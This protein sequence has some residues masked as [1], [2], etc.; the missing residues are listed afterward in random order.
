M[1]SFSLNGLSK[2]FRSTTDPLPDLHRM[3]PQVRCNL[4]RMKD[5]R[6]CRYGSSESSVLLSWPVIKPDVNERGSNSVHLFSESIPP[7]SELQLT[8]KLSKGGQVI[9]SLYRILPHQSA[10]LGAPLRLTACGSRTGRP[11][12][13]TAAVTETSVCE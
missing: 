9:M 3:P 8:M 11:Q 2:L 4:D 5:R 13:H 7:V 10:C 12:R 1:G 6:T